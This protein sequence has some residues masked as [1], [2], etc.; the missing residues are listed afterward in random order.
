MIWYW[1]DINLTS[2]QCWIN[3]LKFYKVGVA[4]QNIRKNT[5]HANLRLI[6]TLIS[7]YTLAFYNNK[8]KK[9]LKRID[10]III[11]EIFIVLV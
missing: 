3:L 5:I 8:F 9:K 10:T 7:F 4:T 11:K 2:N 1:F 6:S